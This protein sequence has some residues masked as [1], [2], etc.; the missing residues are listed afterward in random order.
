MASHATPSAGSHS[1]AVRFPGAPRRV[2]VVTVHHI[3]VDG[4]T[5][6]GGAE[7]YI[8]QTIGA[9]LD[10]GVAVHVGYSG[11]SIYDDLLHDADPTQFT[12]ERTGW[13]NSVL[14]GDARLRLG[15]IRARRRWLRATRADTLFVVH[16]VGGA[17]FGA[18][19]VAA[20]SLGMR[21]VASM[22]QTPQPLPPVVPKRWLGL[23]PTPKLWWR[24]LLWRRRIPAWCC[25]AIIFNSRRVAWAHHEEYGFPRHRCRVIYNGEA[26]RPE[27]RTTPADPPRNIASVGRVTESKGSDTLL[28]AFAAV[29][30]AFPQT[31]LTYYG[32][33]PLIPGLRARAQAL[34]LGD[35]VSF[36]GYQK[37]HERIYPNIDICVQPSRREAMSNSVVEAMTRGIPCVVS[38]VGGL[39]ETVVD[40]ESGFVVPAN[41]PR[42]CAD[43]LTRL[44]S[45]RSTLMRFRRAS[46][47][48]ARKVFDV[49]RAMRETVETI[50]GVAPEPIV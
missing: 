10:A 9:L 29:A 2:A 23:I 40:G 35:R 14:S 33:G 47:D 24:R 12:V 15:T 31:R 46:A 5:Y 17:A 27:T 38:D 30:G 39:P 43:A 20:R 44:L 25:N 21:V 50:L 16:P 1:A 34:G 26:R 36:A 3:R 42:A 32:D 37:D 41:Q 8:R 45:D 11:Q 4:Q 13:L 6:T 19:L 22:R 49:H 28:E 18:S 48:R 7:K